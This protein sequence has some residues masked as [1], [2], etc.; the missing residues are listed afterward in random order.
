METRKKFVIAT[1]FLL[2]AVFMVACGQTG[3]ATKNT[4]RVT[5]TT[6][7]DNTLVVLTPKDGGNVIS[8]G[9]TPVISRVVPEGRYAM[10]L[11]SEG[12]HT[13]TMGVQVQGAQSVNVNLDLTPNT[14]NE[15]QG[16]A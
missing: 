2:L 12:F 4:G 16:L 9:E 1:L 5:V 10:T 15:N 6:N 11:S 14:D 13:F 7:A 3:N 8:L